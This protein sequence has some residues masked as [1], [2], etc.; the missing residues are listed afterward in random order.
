MSSST[1][2][3]DHI[4]A[5]KIP[6]TRLQACAVDSCICP[7]RCAVHHVFSQCKLAEHIVS[8]YRWTHLDIR[9]HRCSPIHSEI[10]RSAHNRRSEPMDPRVEP[11]EPSAHG[12]CALPSQQTHELRRRGCE[13]GVDTSSAL[14]SWSILQPI[15]SLPRASPASARFSKTCGQCRPHSAAQAF[16]SMHLF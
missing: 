16:A 1:R 9:D 2:P 10:N 6:V 14:A 4:D 13:A 8:C 3:R 15:V 12:D 7:A 5:T 11:M